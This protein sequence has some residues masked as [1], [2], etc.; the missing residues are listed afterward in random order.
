M[1]NNNGKVFAIAGFVLSIVAVVLG[2]FGIL[3]LIA[4]PASIVGLVLSVIGRKKCA[5]ANTPMGLGTAGFVLGIVAVS[6]TGI[7]F[8]TCGLCSVCYVIEFGEL[9]LF[10]DMF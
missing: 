1:E 4:L 9:A 5:L 8:L 3:A 7:Q 10:G 2:F 6:I